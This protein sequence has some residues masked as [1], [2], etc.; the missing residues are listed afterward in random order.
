M[1][2][3]SSYKITICIAISIL[4]HS[5]YLQYSILIIGIGFKNT[6][7]DSRAGLID[8]FFKSILS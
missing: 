4:K 6:F 8:I 2:T 7:K 1:A 5:I 3:P